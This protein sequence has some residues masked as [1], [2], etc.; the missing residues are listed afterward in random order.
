MHVCACMYVCVCV[1]DC[2]LLSFVLFCARFLNWFL[3][4][5][6]MRFV[7]VAGAKFCIRSVFTL[8]YL[9]FLLAVVVVVLNQFSMCAH[10]YRLLTLIKIQ[11]HKQQLYIKYLQYPP[12]LPLVARSTRNLLRSFK[13]NYPVCCEIGVRL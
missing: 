1:S 3:S 13:K 4:L 12:S 2:A 11:I 9:L 5:I 7:V 8:L 6:T 10:S